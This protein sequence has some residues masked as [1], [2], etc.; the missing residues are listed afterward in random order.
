L[1]SG[2]TGRAAG[3]GT[4]AGA[5]AAA[6]FATTVFFAAGAFLAG[7]RVGM[8]WTLVIDINDLYNKPGP[9]RYRETAGARRRFGASIHLIQPEQHP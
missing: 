1:T 8:D 9:A 7:V 4:A 5:G 3:A 2:W 6:F